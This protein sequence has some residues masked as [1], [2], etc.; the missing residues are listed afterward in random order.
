MG[1]SSRESGQLRAVPGEDFRRDS[2]D[3]RDADGS[4]LLDERRHGLLGDIGGVG[5]SLSQHAETAI[6]RIGSGRIAIVRELFR[7][8]VTAEGTRAVRE[9]D[10]LLSVFDSGDDTKQTVGAGFTPA[11]E[12]A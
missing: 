1:I 10:E 9:W 3:Y 11:R 7:N 12:S 6:D 8:L 2:A 4:K 5:G